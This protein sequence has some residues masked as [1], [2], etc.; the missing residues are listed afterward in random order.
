MQELAPN[1]RIKGSFIRVDV[2]DNEYTILQRGQGWF[3][4]DAAG[5]N[6]TFEGWEQPLKDVAEDE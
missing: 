5:K 4:I 2:T 3:R 1:G 6:F